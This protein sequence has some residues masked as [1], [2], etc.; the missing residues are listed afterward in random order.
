M[1]LLNFYTKKQ[2]DTIKETHDYGLEHLCP[3][4]HKLKNSFASVGTDRQG[5]HLG[6]ATEI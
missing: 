4:I 2:K 1:K 3:R 6:P 5:C